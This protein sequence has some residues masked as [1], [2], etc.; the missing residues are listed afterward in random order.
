MPLFFMC[1]TIRQIAAAINTAPETIYSPERL[2]RYAK[3]KAA[4]DIS[5]SVFS[6]LIYTYGSYAG[7]VS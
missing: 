2:K 3:M 1:R 7:S 6:L 4:V 5:N